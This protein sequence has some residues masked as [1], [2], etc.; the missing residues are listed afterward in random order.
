MARKLL[1][2]PGWKVIKGD[3]ARRYINDATGQIISRRAHQT[4]QYGQSAEKQAEQNRESRGKT[5]KKSKYKIFVD[6][7]KSKQAAEQGLKQSQIK[8][9][10]QSP[11]AIAFREKM[12]ELKK[13]NKGK[14]ID[15]A[16]G[17]RLAQILESLGVREKDAP[18]PVGQSPTTNTQ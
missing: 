18:Y 4:L 12:R 15:R 16:P 13:L 17:G 7:Y 9:R 10:G 3:K 2:V 6:R 5:G 8:V 1:P 11:E 14:N